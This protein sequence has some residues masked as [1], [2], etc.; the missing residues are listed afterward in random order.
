[1]N[2]SWEAAS[3]YAVLLALTWG[4]APWVRLLARRLPDGGA[5]I[6]RP[7]ALLATV[8]PLWLLA[9]LDLLPYS[10]TGLWLTWAVLTASGWWAAFRHRL[11][12][13]DW[14]RALLVAEL[15]AVV[16]FVSYVWLRGY[17]PDISGTEKPMDSAF[18]SSS[19]RAVSMPPTDPWF[20]GKPI[21]YY[22]LGFLLHGSVARLATVPTSI[23]FNLA[24][25]TTFSMAFVAA[26]GLAFN[27]SRR[28]LN[29]GLSLISGGLA[30]VLLVLVGNLYAAQRLIVA[31]EAAWNAWWWDKK[32]G[33][34]WRASRIVCDGP[35]IANDCKSPSTE[36]INEFPFFSFL[37]GDLHPHVMALPFTVL[38]LSLALNLLPIG[39]WSGNRRRGW[40]EAAVII[41]SGAAIGALYPLNSWD[42]PTFLLIAVAALWFAARR[43]RLRHRLIALGTLIAASVLA[44]LPFVLTF[45]P[46]VGADSSALRPA[47][48]GIPLVSTLAATLGTVTGERTSVGEFLTIFGVPY[49]GAVWLILSGFGRRE[50]TARDSGGYGTAGVVLAGAGFAAL[51]LPAPVVLLCVVPVVGGI[52]LL[53]RQR[54]VD[55]RF[56]ALALYVIGFLLVLP[57]EFFF[58]RDVFNNRMNTLFKVYYQVW[59]VFAVATALT[60]VVLWREYGPRSLGRFAVGGILAAALVAGLSYPVVASYQWT[61][62]FTG[63]RNLDGAA[64]VGDWS[65]DELAAIRWL[66]DH[67]RANDVLVEA[68]CSYSYKNADGV[69]VNRA[70]AFSGVPTVAGWG[71]HERQWR[72]GEPGY[73]EEIDRREQDARAILENPSGP[74]LDRYGVTLLY[75]GTFEREGAR[76]CKDAEAEPVEAASLPGYPGPGWQ[77]VFTSDDV[78]IYRRTTVAR[79]D[80]AA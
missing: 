24:L 7:L 66:R 54:T 75:V 34:G 47:I 6:A 17:T 14:I 58:L 9:S 69:P 55:G 23:G 53:R 45:T 57:T 42:Y 10:T 43:F 27:A 74:L 71:G 78:Q 32:V 26:G 46:P 4:I 2:W 20:A 15:A 51:L 61:D 50:E 38:A 5:S 41:A 18:L 80:P 60:A 48:R 19:S 28:W 73:A 22:Y 79:A 11:V 77:E 52:E 64:Y 72:N 40:R 37:L 68:G 33:I 13:R 30:S 56:I 62:G 39:R 21:N 36:T 70:S 35:R 65:P 76:G 12:S 67:A 44:W 8:Y 29:R 1:M 25:A 49:L 63:L 16:V 59:T 3:W 31:P